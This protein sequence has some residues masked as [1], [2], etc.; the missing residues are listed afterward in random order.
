MTFVE[1]LVDPQM[2]SIGGECPLLIRLAGASLPAHAGWGQFFGVCVLCGVGFTM[3]LFI[4]SLAF[5]GAEA[6]YEAQVKLGVLLGSLV[7]AALGTLLLLMAQT[8]RSAPAT[9]PLGHSTGSAM[10]PGICAYP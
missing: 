7:S 5:E 3:S 6:M 4:G 9:L 8:D 10:L 1:G 2:N